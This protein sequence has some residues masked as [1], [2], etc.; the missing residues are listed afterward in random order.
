VVE[1]GFLRTPASE[2][3]RHGHFLLLFLGQ[4]AAPKKRAYLPEWEP[5]V[6]QSRSVHELVGGEGRRGGG[7]GD[8]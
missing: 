6:K 7:E 2:A 5:N 3:Q 4:D 8:P 1:W